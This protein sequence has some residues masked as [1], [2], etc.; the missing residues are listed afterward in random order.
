MAAT[1]LSFTPGPWNTRRAPPLSPAQVG[2]PLFASVCNGYKE[3]RKSS[4]PR[5][6]G[7]CSRKRQAAI[8]RP[9]A[10]TA[11]QCACEMSCCIP[12]GAGAAGLWR[13]PPQPPRKGR[14]LILRVARLGLPPEKQAQ[15]VFVNET[16]RSC[17][18]THRTE[19]EGST[20]PTTPT[21]NTR[22]TVSG[23]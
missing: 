7:T 9:A 16:H 2:N 23:T 18:S 6:Q 14:E 4:L 17:E 15:L 13:E 3:S 8:L 19:T 11:C 12:L 10:H 21:T 22:T 20:T 5:G 1:W